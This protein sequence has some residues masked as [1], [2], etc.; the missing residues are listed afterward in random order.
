[1]YRHW[2]LRNVP[3]GRAGHRFEIDPKTT[4][5]FPGRGR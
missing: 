1:V 5:D 3:R 4:C 2:L